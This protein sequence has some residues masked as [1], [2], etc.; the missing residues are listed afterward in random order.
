MSLTLSCALPSSLESHEHARCAE[1]LGYQRAWFYDSPALYADVWVQ[2]C[3]AAERTSQI[4][5]G[6]GVFVPSL[7]HPMVTASAISQL[8]SIA[9]PRVAVGVGTGFTGR[10]CMGQRPSRWSDVA[11]YI[12]AVKALLRGEKVDWEGAIMQM[13]HYPGSGSSRPIEVPWVIAASGPKGIEVAKQHGDGVFSSPAPIPGF[14]WSAVLGFGTVL[15]DGE[16]PGSE[17]ALAA[18]GHAASMFMHYAVEFG[19]YDAF[20]GA[21]E[22]A[23]AYAD[24]PADERHLE[25][26]QGHLVAVNERDAKFI[27]GDVMTATGVALPA[28]G[29]RERLAGMEESG[30]TEV[31]YQP[32]GPDVPRELEAFANAF[33]GY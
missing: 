6:P 9:G 27:T 12:V 2:L 30:A 31:V 28:A 32:A 26:H 24:V 22:L 8:V 7:R 15:D 1:K 18:A 11:R 16:D 13:L 4:G 33:A 10:V 23:R 20:I 19:Q 17:R 5:L 14:E 25:M 3:R 21:R 29:W